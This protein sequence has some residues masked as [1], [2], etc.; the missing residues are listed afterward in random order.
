MPR[1][2]RVSWRVFVAVLGQVLSRTVEGGPVGESVI[3]KVSGVGLL[4]RSSPR[5]WGR[6][7]EVMIAGAQKHRKAAA[8]NKLSNYSMNPT[9]GGASLLPPVNG[10]GGARVQ[11]VE[12]PA[13]GYAER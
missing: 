12:P 13:A 1:C 6:L 7:G 3:G 8:G 2:Q 4:Q 11:E 5:L 9:P 10:R